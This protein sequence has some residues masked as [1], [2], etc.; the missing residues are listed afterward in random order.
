M[1]RRIEI[2][3]R[4]LTGGRLSISARTTSKVEARKREVAIRTLLDQ[5]MF[6]VIDAVRDRSSGLRIG[7]V[8]R[9]VRER[10]W[11]ELQRRAARVDPNPVTLGPALTQALRTIRATL[12]PGSVVQYETVERQLLERW[13]A[14]FDMAALTREDAEAFLHEPKKRP[15]KNGA[16]KPWSPARQESFAVLAGRVW[17]EAIDREAE[18][19]KRSGLA[20]RVVDNPWRAARTAGKRTS[21]SEYLQP[22]EWDRVLV[23]V[24]RTPAALLL[25]LG[26]YAGLRKMEA[27]NLR[28]D[29]DVDLDAR[30][31]HVQPREGGF[32]WKPKT[33]RSVRTVP[34]NDRLHAL[35]VEHD[36]AGFAGDRYWIRTP[37]TDQPPTASTLS[38]WTKDAFEAAGLRYGR[39]AEA[40][41]YHSLRHTFASWLVQAGVSPLVVAQLLGDTLLMVERVYGHLA[42]RN[43]REAVAVLDR[44]GG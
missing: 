13:G 5:G 11:D 37:Y 34:I 41:T 26:T 16:T 10:K 22:E 42:P 30:E 39:A 29:L 18:A 24:A 32:G 3:D 35:F 25:G 20:P 38:K 14:E 36:A 12:E 7:E 17:Q 40:V 27:A 23:K 33:D 2:V 21:R 1:S 31:L 44:I 9:L 4:R 19:S 28:R 43:Y 6:R 15:G 8:E